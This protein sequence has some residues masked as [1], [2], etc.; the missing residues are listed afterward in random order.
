[1]QFFN[2]SN[3]EAVILAIH[4]AGVIR[5]CKDFKK[6]QSGEK[7]SESEED[8]LEHPTDDTDAFDTLYIGCENFPFRDTFTSSL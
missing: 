8:L 6:D 7:P 3:N 1:M 2:R 5:G 4:T